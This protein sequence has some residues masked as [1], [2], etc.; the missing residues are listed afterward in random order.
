[1]ISAENLIT[2]ELIGLKTE[3]QESSNPQIIGINGQIVDETKHMFLLLTNNGFKMLSKK[4]NKWG[5]F[6]NDQ[7]ISVSGSLLGKRA[8][9]R[10]VSKN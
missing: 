9:E 4:H 5:F 6:L 8:Y 2:H 3:V 7:K 10:I 1:M